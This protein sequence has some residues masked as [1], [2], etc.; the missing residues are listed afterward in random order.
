MMKLKS[1]FIFIIKIKFK[2]HLKMKDL[3]E[4][5]D[6]LVKIEYLDHC[7]A[8][9]FYPFQMFVEAA[10]EK[11]TICA[12][13]LGGDLRAVYKAF[14]DF[15]KDKAKRIYLAVDFPANMDIEN[16]FVCII[17]Y[18]NDEFKLTAIPYNPETGEIFPEIKVA[19]ILNKIFEDLSHFIS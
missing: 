12:L 18:Q 1:G 13:D 3:K 11:L 15:H 4:F 7:S 14:S 19:E 16:D 10:D 17:N 5:V 9:G 8:F 6:T 2:Q